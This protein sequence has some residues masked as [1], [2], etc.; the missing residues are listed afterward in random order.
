MNEQGKEQ[1]SDQPIQFSKRIK[2]SQSS[3]SFDYRIAD[4]DWC[5]LIT[6]VEHIKR[7]RVQLNPVTLEKVPLRFAPFQRLLTVDRFNL[8]PKRMKYNQETF[9][10]DLLFDRLFRATEYFQQRLFQET[11]RI[12]VYYD[13]D[14]LSFIKHEAVEKVCASWYYAEYS[15]FEKSRTLITGYVH[16]DVGIGLQRK[17]M[18]HSD[19]CGVIQLFLKFDEHLQTST[20]WSWFD[21]FNRPFGDLDYD[22]QHEWQ[23]ELKRRNEPHL[24]FNATKMTMYGH[25]FDR[26]DVIG[27]INEEI[28]SARQHP[29][30]ISLESFYAF[31]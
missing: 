1:H 14:A 18:E 25:I 15:D 22:F 4:I 12:W 28:Q 6:N 21:A 17:T 11:Q 31:Q 29:E 10:C 7:N 5:T 26:Y 27:L 19:V 30:H 2:Q 8:L 9:Q 24:E 23:V 13:F 3:V 20:K 16:A